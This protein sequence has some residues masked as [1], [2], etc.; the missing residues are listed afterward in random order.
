MNKLGTFIATCALTLPMQVFAE[1]S[2][3]AV[4]ELADGAT[5]EIDQLVSSQAAVKAYQEQVEVFRKCLETEEMVDQ[6]DGEVLPEDQAARLAE[7]NAS[8]D[9]EEAV[10]ASWNEEITEYKAREAAK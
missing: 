8:V 4:P 2:R 1:C 7:H 5:A 10:A 3:P 6:E 9:E